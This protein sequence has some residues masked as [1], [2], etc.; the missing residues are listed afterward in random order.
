LEQI[1][2]RLRGF[3]FVQAKGITILQGEM[4]AKELKYTE[5]F[6]FKSSSPEPAGQTQ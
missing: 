3:K 1:I 2:L 6:F 5:F 4:I